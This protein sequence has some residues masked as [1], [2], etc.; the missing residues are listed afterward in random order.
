MRYNRYVEQA[1]KNLLQAGYSVGRWGTDGKFGEDTLSAV[2]M[3]IA[4]AKK[5]DEAADDEDESQKQNMEYEFAGELKYGDSG[6]DVANLQRL[7]IKWHMGYYLGKA[8][9]DGKYGRGTKEAVTEMQK[10]MGM[11]P[12]G[13]ADESLWEALNRQPVDISRWTTPQ[14]GQLPFACNCK[15]KYCKSQTDAQPGRT[16]VGL[17]IMIERVEAELCRRFGREDIEL[18]LTDDMNPNDDDDRNGG[19]RCTRWNKAHG[20]ASGSQHIY[21]RAAD[22]FVV[23]PDV[24]GKSKP[25]I[26]SLYTVADEM[27]P[28][29]GVGEYKGNIHIDTRGWK[30]RW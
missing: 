21:R 29:G 4:D 18:R 16:S 5:T 26:H 12:S 3:A 28:Y 24:E 20:G 14:N 6:E 22:L 13:T 9:A 25:S 11:K 10:G 7:L 27:N 15:G 19:N 17:M 2:N 1:Q 8:Q 23:C 30:S